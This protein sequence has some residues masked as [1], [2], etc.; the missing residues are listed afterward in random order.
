MENVFI[1]GSE[2]KEVI[3]SSKFFHVNFKI[4]ALGNPTAYCNMSQCYADGD[5]I[6]KDSEHAFRLLKKSVKMG[7]FREANLLV[8]AMKLV[9]VL[10]RILIKQLSAII[11]VL[12]FVMFTLYLT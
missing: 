5:G 10:R 3:N 9:M 8:F 1:L 2:Y 7:D 6:E 12:N 11:M 4:A